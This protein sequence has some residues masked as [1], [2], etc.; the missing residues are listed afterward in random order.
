M[1]IR[2]VEYVIPRRFLLR[3]DRCAVGHSPD[4]HETGGQ[5]GKM[6][7]RIEGQQMEAKRIK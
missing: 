1:V 3:R 7:I 4:Q 2:T 6:L 5:A